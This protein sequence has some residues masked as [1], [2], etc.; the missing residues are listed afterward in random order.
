M[1]IS[2][3]NN[4]IGTIQNIKE[5]G[6]MCREKGV[7]LMVDGIQ[8][9][10]K[11]PVDVDEMNIDLMSM[12][13]HC[14]YGPKG[15]G[16][17]YVRQKP[18]VKLA[19]IVTGGGQERGLRS[20]TLAPFLTVGMGR[21]CEVAHHEMEHDLAHIKTLYNKMLTYIQQNIEDVRINGCTESRYPGN[22]NLTFPFTDNEKLIM[23]LK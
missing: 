11:I 14:M 21:A 7:L 6:R 10:G 16:A 3:V 15:V 9:V 13:A 17:L 18:R 1:A 22:L 23:S 12:A 8:G 2:I 20:G 19:P 4:E 5:I